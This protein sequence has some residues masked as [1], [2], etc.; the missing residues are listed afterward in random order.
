MEL[1]KKAGN[2]TGDPTRVMRIIGGRKRTEAE[3]V[4]MIE[5]EFHEQVD[6]Q[7]IA[8]YARIPNEIEQAIEAFADKHLKTQE[9]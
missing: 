7:L 9:R 5:A 4:R 2:L 8:D 6:S 1:D 3:L